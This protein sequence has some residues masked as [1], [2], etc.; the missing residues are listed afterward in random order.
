MN[1]MKIAA[2]GAV[3]AM[4]FAASV[5]AK[6]YK[7][8]VDGTFAPHAMPKLSGGVEASTS[9]LPTSSASALAPKWI[10]LQ[11]NGPGFCRVCRPVP[12]TFWSPRPR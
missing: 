8:A 5:E 3:T 6:T 4:A 7:V 10:S 9:I 11:R 2:I 1:F 12:T